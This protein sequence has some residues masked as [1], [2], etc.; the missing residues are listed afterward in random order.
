MSVVEAAEPAGLSEAEAADRLAR[1]LGNASGERTSRSFGQIVRA[2][3]FT[4]FNAL[5]G[6][7]LV[8][9][10]ATG[11]WQDA[12][13]GV[14]L[15]VNA[16]IGI[17]QEVR[18]KR[19]LD[20]L[21][22]L[23][24][25]HARVVRDGRTRPVELEQVVLG[26]VLELSAGDQVPAD[27]EVLVG[28]GL[29]VDESMLTGE[30]DPIPKRPGDPV[31]S[32]GVVV[33]GRGLARTTAVG[34]DS[35]ARRIAADARRFTLTHSELQTGIN[36]LLGWISWVLV[37]VGPI[38]LVSQLHLHGGWRS[39]VTGTAA[40]LVGMVPEGL[41]LLT[42][43][44]F[45]VAMLTLSRRGVLVQE[46]PAVEGLARVDV[47]CLD[48]TG[49]LTEGRPRFG[50]FEPV[51]AT[52][53]GV[54]PDAPLA[55]DGA[56]PEDPL[57]LDDLPAV[58]G[59]LA[60]RPDPNATLLALREAFPAPDGWQAEEAVAFSSARKWS[61]V[62]FAGHG[63]W[64]LGAPEVV[65]TSPGARQ[66]L[67]RAE[68]LA[69]QGRRV[70]VLAAACGDGALDGADDGADDGEA[71]GPT[72]PEVRPVALLMFDERV[73]PDAAGTLAYFTRQSIAIKII[74]GDSPR[75]LRAV[76]AT[77]GV[78][79]ADLVVDAQ[80]L[81]EDAE[82]LADALTGHSVFGRVTPQQKRA[83]VKAL[84]GRGH[85]VAMTGDGVN[86]ALALKDA[87]IGV[88]MG[89]GAPATRAV[90][91]LVLVDNRFDRLPGV[92]AEGRRV[93]ANIERVAGL[94]V[95]KNVYSAILSLAVAVAAFPYPFLPRQL[96]VISTLTI[97]LPAFVLALA[98]NP[99][100]F[101]PG[102]LRRVL[103]FSVPAGV[104]VGAGSFVSFW[105]ARLLS[106][107]E[108]QARTAASI[109]VLLAGL[110]ILILLSRPLAVWKLALVASV[111]GVFA[112]GLAVPVV[113]DFFQ[114]AVPLDGLAEA[115][116][117][118][119]GIAAS[120]TVVLRVSEGP[121]GLGRPDDAR[122]DTPPSDDTPPSRDHA[123]RSRE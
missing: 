122:P 118:G 24:A 36:R 51:G 107:P 32:G 49:T 37:V 85:V 42:S 14:V 26:D 119:V 123:I 7:L 53:D 113:R 117:L 18:A 72:L 39:A 86:D 80:D 41:V 87:D 25:P 66:V 12:A 99:Q 97:G 55:L 108:D 84:R 104:L 35:Y 54:T 1:G 34:P 105:L 23:S 48:K 77:V 33:A 62:R 13:F 60:A 74:S 3:V 30:S 16:G 57:A 95:V 121:V 64:V 29:E 31:L 9:V 76:A 58:L 63:V 67:R 116:G 10:L 43:V 8:L 103:R 120:A 75:T 45:A 6:T 68:E 59:A 44:A 81:P 73:R 20:R 90:A 71:A 17:V 94:F 15:V 114:L 102:F 111:G 69:G 4:R 91:Q 38:L 56:G 79:G 47:L 21:A 61:S 101:R 50:G 19:S 115:T 46:L 100:R 106:L 52:P 65:L 22:V 112:A 83:M 78:P 28:E 5:L 92:V 110:W 82:A 96:T 93:M 89:S 27:A 109:T 88:A 98:P 11:A 2:N 70:L 40:G